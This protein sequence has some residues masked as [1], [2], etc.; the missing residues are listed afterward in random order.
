MGCFVVMGVSGCGK[1]TVGDAVAKSCGMTFVDGD[2]LH[3]AAN[4]EK[5]T[6]GI[7]LTDQDRAPWLAIVGQ[8]LANGVGPTIIGCSALKRKYRDLIREQVSETV[9]FVHLDAAQ[10]VLA[11][12][13]NSRPGHFMPPKLLDSQF[14][15]LERLSTEECGVEIDISKPLEDVIV[16]AENYVRTATI[17]AK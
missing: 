11:E 17:K 12:R 9:C 14:A 7:P 6:Q 8:T 15:I 5:M 13:V 10:D 1:S 4:I 2:D 16:A 3:P